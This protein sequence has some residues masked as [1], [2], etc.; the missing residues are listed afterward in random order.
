MGRARTPTVAKAMA[1]R[2]GGPRG[3]CAW[4]TGPL[5]VRALPT[6]NTENSGLHGGGEGGVG[7][8]GAGETLQ[9]GRGADGGE[10]FAG[11]GGAV[12]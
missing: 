4:R 8:D 9:V 12:G 10:G 11:G 1:G 6:E 2:P 3:A 5:G 7:A